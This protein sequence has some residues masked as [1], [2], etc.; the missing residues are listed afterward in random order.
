VTVKHP[1]EGRIVYSLSSSHGIHRYD[2]LAF[3][4]PL[5]ALLWVLRAD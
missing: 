5:L 4:P 3:V 1:F 2:F